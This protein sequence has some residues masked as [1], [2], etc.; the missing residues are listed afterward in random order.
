MILLSLQEIPYS[1]FY[2]SV[3]NLITHGATSVI[4][5]PLLITIQSNN[6]FIVD[7]YTCVERK[8]RRFQGNTLGQ[9]T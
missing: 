5:L 4:S 9:E 1:Y 2:R 6:K 8:G 7:V 3:L